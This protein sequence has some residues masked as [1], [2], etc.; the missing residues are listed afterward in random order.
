MGKG[1]AVIP[2][3]GK[4]YAPLGGTVAALFPTN[5]AIGIVGDNGVELLIHIGIDTV[6]LNGKYFNPRVKQGD[7]VEQG[8]LLIEFDLHK[9]KAEGYPLETPVLIT[10][11][12]DFET[13]Q[14]EQ[15]KAGDPIIQ[16][17]ER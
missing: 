13:A 17:K 3:E 15:V 14:K 16:I 9:I 6:N 1:L 12:Y 8:Q 5:H 4:V 2:T 7:R 10:N 11:G